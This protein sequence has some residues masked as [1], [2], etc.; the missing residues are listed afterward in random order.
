MQ[1][2]FALALLAGAGW[3]AYSRYQ[4]HAA[5]AFPEASTLSV[6]PNSAPLETP[7]LASK[8]S[9]F[10]CDGRK[11]CSEMHSCKEATYF[12]QNCPD[13]KMDGNH[14]GIP[15]ERQWCATGAR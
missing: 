7:E 4:H 8:A 3:L 5:V 10:T 9:T 2:L 15:C 14:D 13:T 11:Y 12:I 6:I 1:R